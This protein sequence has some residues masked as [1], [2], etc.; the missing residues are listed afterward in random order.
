MSL[1]T[2]YERFIRLCIERQVVINQPIE[3][4]DVTDP[5]NAA[6]NSEKSPKLFGLPKPYTGLK[7]HGNSS[8]IS[9]SSYM[10]NR[11]DY[12]RRREHGTYSRSSLGTNNSNSPTTPN[13]SVNSSG[14]SLGSVGKLPGVAGIMTADTNRLNNS[15]NATL[16]GSR[17][18]PEIVTSNE[19]SMTSV[20]SNKMKN[21]DHLPNENENM[22]NQTKSVCQS[23]GHHAP[24]TTIKDLISKL[25][26]SPPLGSS[27]E[28][29]K[30]TTY[31]ETT[32]KRVTT[33]HKIH[34]TDT[35]PIKIEVS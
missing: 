32:V 27:V 11:P 25:P 29:V 2:G 33:N 3:P 24:D 7:I 19:V 35:D 5:P 10:A 1:L 15:K 14:G 6:F 30:R 22:T 23:D 4:T 21:I 26:A 9:P 34:G 8:Y 18:F 20:P 31:T 17:T 16:P 28:T 12:M 13:T